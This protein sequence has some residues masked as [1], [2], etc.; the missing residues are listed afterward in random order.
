[1][2]RPKLYVAVLIAALVVVTQR[3]APSFRRLLIE[4]A[5]R[6]MRRAAS[7]RII[8]TQSAECRPELIVGPDR[9][10]ICEVSVHLLLDRGR[11]HDLG[12][13]ALHNDALNPLIGG[14]AGVVLINSI[15]PHS[16]KLSLGG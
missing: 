2:F 8:V 14:R 9:R 3:I 11:Q 12:R 6:K 13:C 15:V 16:G 4:P 5:A 10:L 7:T 1:M